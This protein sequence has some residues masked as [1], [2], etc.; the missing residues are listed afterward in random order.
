MNTLSHLAIRRIQ[1]ITT[2]LATD[3]LAG[4]YRSAF[5]GRGMEFEEVREYQPGDEI[6][7]IDW[8]V[9]ARMNHPYVKLFREERDLTVIL[10]VDISA[11]MRFGSAE[12]AKSA[13]VAEIGAVLAF[14]AI[15]NNDRVGLILFSD[16]VEKYVPP[17]KGTRH[18][19]RLIRE[20]LFAEPSHRASDLA[21]AFAFL[22]KVQSR[23]GI[24]FLL[25][26][27]L[28]PEC[29]HDAVLIA[30]KHDLIA[31]CLRDPKENQISALGLTKLAD[32][33]TGKEEL[34][35]TSDA[36]VQKGFSEAI[37][38]Q[39]K[40]FETLIKQSGAGWIS[41]VTD[42]PYVHSFKRF[43]QMRQRRRL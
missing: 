16:T 5:K 36:V 27:F 19:L 40:K 23:R 12:R 24:C 37:A 32:L 31:I 35:D 11:S 1:I 42:K 38:A 34:L 13:L 9:T 21:G 33:E 14:S 43:F 22:G 8:N 6:R 18:V 39:Q 25:S 15:K 26:D 17:R 20:L 7:T 3:V 29:K 30:K 10:M 41:L 2:Q 4:A 28:C